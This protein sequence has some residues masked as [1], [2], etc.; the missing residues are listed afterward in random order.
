MHL[1]FGADTMTSSVTVDVRFA[2][3]HD[4]AEISRI[5]NQGIARRIATFETR[6]RSAADIEGWFGNPAHPILIAEIDGTAA[7]WIAASTYRTRECYAG[8]AEFSV[9]I[10]GEQQGKGVG[11]RL[12]ESFIPACEAAGLWKLVSRIFPENTASRALC[13]RFG[14]REVG[15]YEKHAKLDGVWRDVIIVERLLEVNLR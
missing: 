5:Y 13:R 4:A 7:G 2:E 15:T 9:Y 3:I 10:D 14:F 12:M 11:S 8:I 6:M 1:P